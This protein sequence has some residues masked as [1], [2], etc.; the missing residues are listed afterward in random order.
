[1]YEDFE[2]QEVTVSTTAAMQDDFG[3]IYLD[4]PTKTGTGTAVGNIVSNTV[5]F[6]GL[7]MFVPK[8]GSA[9]M[10]V[11]ADIVTITAAADSGDEGDLTLAVNNSQTFRAVGLGSGSVDT[12]PDDSS[13]VV[14][15]QND[16]A[17]NDMVVR[18]TRPTVTLASLPTATLTNG[19]KTVSKFTVSADA[20]EDVSLYEI[21]W[22][23]ST[24]GAVMTLSSAQLYDNANPSTVL[25]ASG[26]PAFTHNNGGTI[27]YQLASEEVIPAGTSK[28]YFLNVTVNGSNG[29]DSLLTRLRSPY[30]T[31]VTTNAYDAAVNATF[32]WSDNSASGHSYTTSDWG[33]AQYVKTLPSDYQTLS[34][35]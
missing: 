33:N 5:T 16:V 19:T 18:K 15:S 4:Y 31:T 27:K 22:D 13:G 7:N 32:V 12:N 8:D 3:T 14:Q 20:A 24:S 23:F 10:D 30:T 11:S 17:G 6:T 25:T 34:N 28:T 29:S 2:V 9:V 26:T 35:N 1:L 21:E